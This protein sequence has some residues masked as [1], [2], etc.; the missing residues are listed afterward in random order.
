[1]Q[2]YKKRPEPILSEAVQAEQFKWDAVYTIDGKEYAGK[3]GDW[4]M[5]SSE[6]GKKAI[7]VMSDDDFNKK[8]SSDLLD[9]NTFDTLFSHP[10]FRRGYLK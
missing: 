2:L 5:F 6:N 1:M 3:A 9:F 7:T 10:F 8:Y 4:L